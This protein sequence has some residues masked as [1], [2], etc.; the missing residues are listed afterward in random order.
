M[1]E[2]KK[3]GHGEERVGAHEHTP[4][5]ITTDNDLPR[6]HFMCATCDAEW[7]EDAETARLT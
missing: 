3:A 6:R 2:Q 5:D 4:I 7:W 1:S